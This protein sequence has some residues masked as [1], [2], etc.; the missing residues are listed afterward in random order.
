MIMMSIVFMMWYMTKHHA[1][2]NKDLGFVAPPFF[3]ILL[4]T[5]NFYSSIMSHQQISKFCI[6]PP[7]Q[8]PKLMVCTKKVKQAAKKAMMF[9]L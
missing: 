8:N 6:T 3:V 4:I 1:C 9:I 7:N 2:F 5:Y